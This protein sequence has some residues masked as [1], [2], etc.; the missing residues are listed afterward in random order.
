MLTPRSPG[1]GRWF[2]PGACPLDKNEAVVGVGDVRRQARQVM[3][4]LAEALA[5]AG[6]ALTDVL[7]TTVYVASGDR[8]DLVAAWEVVRAA[9]GEHDAP[10]T[11]LGVTALGYRDQLVETEAVALLSGPGTEK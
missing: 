6:A 9:F 4:N 11:L 3:A 2:S 5:A 1:R 8:G 10:S 7:K